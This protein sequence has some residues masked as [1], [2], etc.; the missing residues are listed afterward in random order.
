MSLPADLPA[1]ARPSPVCLAPSSP[2]P[3]KVPIGPANFFGLQIHGVKFSSHPPQRRLIGLTC[4]TAS[5]LRGYAALGAQLIFQLLY[6]KHWR[7]GREE[8][9]HDMLKK[10]EYLRCFFR[11]H[12]CFHHFPLRYWSF[13]WRKIKKT[14]TT[15]TTSTS[16]T[17][18]K[19]IMF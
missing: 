4:C 14:T 19:S 5:R 3:V 7:D 13:L 9:E 15:S 16:N 17:F 2:A 11:I 6:L 10:S 1:P 8:E 12:P 18:I